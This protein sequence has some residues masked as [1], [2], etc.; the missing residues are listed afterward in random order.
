MRWK[1]ESTVVKEVKSLDRVSGLL[2]GRMDARSESCSQTEAT[3]LML[4]TRIESARRYSS[5]VR[6]SCNVA[7]SQERIDEWLVL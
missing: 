5:K 3:P 1:S 2:M 4:K 6:A 7:L